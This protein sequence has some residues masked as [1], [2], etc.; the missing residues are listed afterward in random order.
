MEVSSWEKRTREA[1]VLQTVQQKECSP[2]SVHI[3]RIT[4]GRFKTAVFALFAFLWIFLFS[5]QVSELIS[6]SEIF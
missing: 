4:M 2:V 6:A 5:L 1:L 3:S